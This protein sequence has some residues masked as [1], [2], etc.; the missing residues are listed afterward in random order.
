VIFFQKLAKHI[1]MSS[2]TFEISYYHHVYFGDYFFEDNKLVIDDVHT[3]DDV[4]RIEIDSINDSEVF[5]KVYGLVEKKHGYENV[6]HDEYE[7]E[8]RYSIAEERGEERRKYF[9]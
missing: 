2:K 6:E 9:S 4:E 7:A 1:V 8:L 5:G 3:F